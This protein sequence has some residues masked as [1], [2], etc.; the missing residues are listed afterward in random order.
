MKKSKE[1]II[2]EI[3]ELKKDTTLD[4]KIKIQKLQQELDNIEYEKQNQ[5][6]L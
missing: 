6:N 4:N 5:K 2:Q 3:I 1:Q